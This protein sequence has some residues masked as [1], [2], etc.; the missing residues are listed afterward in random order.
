MVVL[1]TIFWVLWREYAKIQGKIRE[2]LVPATEGECSPAAQLCRL[3]GQ[4]MAQEIKSTLMGINSGESRLA[5]ATEA[6]I[7]QDAAS[8]KSPLL[9]GLLQ[10][11]PSLSKRLRKN[12]ALM[13]AILTLLPQ[14]SGGGADRPSPSSDGGAPG[15]SRLYG[16][17]T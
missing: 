9:A 11:A 8:L 4:G 17:Y 15:F 5:A 6:D 10:A 13:Q 7:F 2:F 3:A 14:V 12:P 1:L 16:K